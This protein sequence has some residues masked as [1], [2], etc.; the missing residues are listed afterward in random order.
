MCFPPNKRRRKVSWQS[1]ER[2]KGA[3][4]IKEEEKSLAADQE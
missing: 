3:N 1:Q 2:K 4:N